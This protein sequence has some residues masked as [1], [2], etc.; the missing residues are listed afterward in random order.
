MCS[1]AYLVC[2]TQKNIKDPWSFYIGVVL[3]AYFVSVLSTALGFLAWDMAVNFRSLLNALAHIVLPIYF[4]CLTVKREKEKS[5]LWLTLLGCVATP[6]LES[7]VGRELLIIVWFA[8]AFVCVV[9]EEKW[10]QET[11]LCGQ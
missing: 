1:T 2:S 11:K 6:L 5:I 9:I 8:I 3:T 4:V 7:L 10:K